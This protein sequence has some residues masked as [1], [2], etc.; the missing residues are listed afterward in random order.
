MFFNNTMYLNFFWKKSLFSKTE[1]DV[2]MQQIK[3]FVYKVLNDI[4]KLI[5]LLNI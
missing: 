3:N 4:R 2:S 5:L 1:D